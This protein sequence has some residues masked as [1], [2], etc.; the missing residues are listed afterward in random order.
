MSVKIK[1]YTAVALLEYKQQ[2][3]GEVSISRNESVTV[4]VLMCA[5]TRV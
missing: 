2:E 5:Y 3:A 1:T 4:C